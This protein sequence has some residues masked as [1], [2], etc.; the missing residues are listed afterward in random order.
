MPGQRRRYTQSFH[1]LRTNLGRGETLLSEFFDRPGGRPRRAGQP[2]AHEQELLRSVLVLTVGAL[3]AFLSELVIE[4][5]PRLARAGT[6]H[7]IFNRLMS[8]NA[9]LILQAVYLSPDDLQRALADVIEGHFSAKV[10]HGSRALRQAVDW[11]NLGLSNNDF[12]GQRFL[13]A[14]VT[15]DDWTDKR[16][17][18]VHRG[19]LVRMRRD[20]ATDVIELVRSIGLTLNDR[21][22]QRYF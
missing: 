22:V 19:E 12:D 21:A 2:R 13:T 14:L 6:A 16:H 11:C 3:D 17:R 7:A 10:M 9:G 18:I 1:R 20:D 5:V 8:E 15:L 4:L